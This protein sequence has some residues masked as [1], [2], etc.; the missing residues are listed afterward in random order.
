MLSQHEAHKAI[1]KA[2]LWQHQWLLVDDE[3]QL[4][5]ECSVCPEFF[6]LPTQMKM[7]ECVNISEDKGAKLVLEEDE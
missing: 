3:G 4:R 2:S 5:L 6:N 7:G 1:N